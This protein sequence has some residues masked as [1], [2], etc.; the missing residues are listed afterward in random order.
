MDGED[1]TLL[2]D[3]A[4]DPL[5]RDLGED[6]LARIDRFLVLLDVWNPRIRLTGERDRAV[7]V[8]KHTADSLAC[9]S[10]LPDSGRILDLGSGAG[11]P[12]AVV[13]CVRLD[14]DVILLD[15]RQKAVSF[16]AEVVRTVPLPRARAVAMRAE[17]A[18]REPGIGGCQHVV[19]SRAVRMEVFVPLAK[20]LLAPGG[21]VVSMQ[22][23]RVEAKAAARIGKLHGLEVVQVFDYRVPSGES[24]RLI[25]WR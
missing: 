25:V 14:L 1:R 12:G 20:S 5:C 6:A 3:F 18:A 7:L 24:R 13:A 22:T 16:L 11:F 23:P 19:M 8:R 2:R 10:V 15:S 17:D 4:R 21:L 9:L